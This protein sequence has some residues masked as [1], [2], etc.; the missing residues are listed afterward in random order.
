MPLSKFHQYLKKL[1]I[2]FWRSFKNDSKWFVIQ[3][4]LKSCNSSHFI[5]MW[6]ESS[7]SVLYN[8]LFESVLLI[9]KNPIMKNFQIRF[10]NIKMFTNS[11]Q[12][13]PFIIKYT[14]IVYFPFY[15]SFEIGYFNSFCINIF[16]NCL[17]NMKNPFFFVIFY[18]KWKIWKQCLFHM[19]IILN[20]VCPLL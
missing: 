17:L 8:G 1:H 18:T 10:Y 20:N 4:C 15:Y 7:H 3:F 13:H 9:C 2:L 5:N 16:K 6:P 12:Y 19:N 14:S 11:S